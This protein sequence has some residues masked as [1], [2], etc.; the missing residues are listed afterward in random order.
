MMIFITAINNINITLEKIINN[1][2]EKDYLKLDLF[3]T[4]C[5]EQKI[6]EMLKSKISIEKIDKLII[7]TSNIISK[8]TLNKSTQLEHT[9]IL[10]NI[11]RKLIFKK[12]LLQN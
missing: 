10:K 11:L 8:L 4:K 2:L 3:L 7:D 9:V 1:Q 5:Y 12:R 6:D